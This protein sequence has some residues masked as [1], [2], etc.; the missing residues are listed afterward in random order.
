[1][2]CYFLRH[3]IAVEP[4]E[5]TGRD[6][7]RPL[8]HDG[9]ER[10]KFEARAI[11]AL[12]LQLDVIVT[13]PLLRA[14]QTAEIVA[15]RLKLRDEIVEDERL[16]NG[17]DA[18]RL[19]EILGEH[20]KAEAI[21]LVGHEPT[22]SA[23]IGRIVGDAQVELK[24]GAF[25]GVALSDASATRGTLSCLIPPKVLTQLGKGRNRS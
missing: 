9:I 13:S 1:M 4:D 3:G 2:N 18:K 7:D 17:F 23:T 15:D 5:W 20:D 10:M 21:M 22:M 6:F 12:S 25:A 11:A 24:K 16:A 14:R 19:S 8:T